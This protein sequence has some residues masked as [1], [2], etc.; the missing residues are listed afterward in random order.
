MCDTWMPVIRLPISMAQFQQLPRNPAYKYEYLDKQ[1]LL[2]PQPRHYHALRDLRPPA[3]VE[4]INLR[5][6]EETDFGLLE[7]PFAA[8]FRGIQPF[9]SLSEEARID[10]AR[11]S[12][13]R[14]RDGGDGPLIRQASF[15]AFDHDVILGGILITLLPKGDPCSWDGLSWDAPPPADVIERKDGQPHLTWVFVTPFNSGH[16]VG[17]ALLARSMAALLGL[18][19]TSLL[20]TFLAGNSSSMLWHWRN[21]FELL[22]FPS[23]GR[24]IKKRLRS[25]E[26]EKQARRGNQ[27]DCSTTQEN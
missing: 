2:S 3:E 27:S 16:G 11:A 15:L 23:S 8:A 13:K 5:R 1:A 12:L 24:L 9:G 17:T 26:E 18:G 7:K 14:T 20:S 25:V 10:A 19:F 21:G 6:V 4:H 22:P